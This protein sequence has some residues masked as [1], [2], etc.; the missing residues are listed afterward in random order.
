MADRSEQ[1]EAAIDQL[2]TLPLGEF[3]AAR[4]EFACRLRREGDSDAGARGHPAALPR[5]VPPAARSARARLPLPGCL[6]PQAAP[7][8][9]ARRGC[10]LRPGIMLRDLLLG[11]ALDSRGSYEYWLSFGRELVGRGMRAPA[12]CRRRARASGR[13]WA[14]CGRPPIASAARCTRCATCSRRCRCATTGSQ[15]ALLEGPRGGRLGRR[16]E[17]GV[18]VPSSPTTGAP[19]PPRCG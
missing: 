4:D 15:G 5:L 3:T 12:L 11:L 9:H 19:S 1:R 7:R 16:G 2:Y 17:A 8:R 14:S 6:L 18:W 13:P 10:R